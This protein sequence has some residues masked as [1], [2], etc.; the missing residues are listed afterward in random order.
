M[1]DHAGKKILILDDEPHVITYLETLLKDNDYETVSAKD[2]IEGLEKAKSDRPDL[3]TLDVSMPEKSGIR[4]YQDLKADPELRE[5]PVVIVTA[6]TGYSG[7]AFPFPELLDDHEELPTPDGFVPK[8]IVR[9]DF[10]SV[11]AKALGATS[12]VPDRE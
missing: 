3:I 2:G 1:A 7:E 12:E 10:L 6:L 4:F 5:I 8:P 11:I 9:E